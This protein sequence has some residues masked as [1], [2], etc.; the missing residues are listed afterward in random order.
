MEHPAPDPEDEPPAHHPVPS[1]AQQH[2]PHTI[3]DIL[4]ADLTGTAYGSVVL[5]STQRGVWD[6]VV[7]GL[8]EADR[9][10]LRKACKTTAAVERVL[11]S[12]PQWIEVGPPQEEEEEESDEEEEEEVSAGGPP[13]ATPVVNLAVDGISASLKD[14]LAAF[15]RFRARE[16]TRRFEIRLGDGAHKTG[17]QRSSGVVGGGRFQGLHLEGDGWDGLRITTPEVCAVYGQE[18]L[19]SVVISEGVQTIGPEAFFRCSSLASVAFPDALQTIGRSAFFECSSLASVALPDAL[20]TIGRSA[21]LG[22]VVW[23]RWPFRVR[24][25]P[26]EAGAFSGCSSLASVAFPDALQTIGRSAFFECSSLASVAFPGA[27]QTIG[28]VHSM[29]AVVWP[30]W[31]FRMRCRP[32]EQCILWVQ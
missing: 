15:K 9:E 17:F 22:A 23:P 7:G 19:A 2:P 12:L 3:P 18:G 29:G 27:L 5:T 8:Q 6:R 14:A 32:S 21:F 11:A 30:R 10:E 26:S 31:P 1:G 4:L 16:P 13:G 25:R 24:C 20:Q 28:D